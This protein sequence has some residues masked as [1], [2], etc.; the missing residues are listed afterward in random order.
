M[1]ILVWAGM[2]LLLA[3][4]GSTVGVAGMI[5]MPIAT[6]VQT[7]VF[8][9]AALV[10]GSGIALLILSRRATPSPLIV[11]ARDQIALN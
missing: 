11:I 10:A 8:V 4:V 9:M 3:V 7:G 1:Q 6:E 5:G 2:F